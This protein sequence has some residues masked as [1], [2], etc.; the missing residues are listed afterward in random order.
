MGFLDDLKGLQRKIADSNQSELARD[1]DMKQQTINRLANVGLESVTARNLAKLADKL[2]YKLTE[3][4][5]GQRTEEE[6]VRDILQR[7]F[8]ACAESPIDDASRMRI[9]ASVTGK[10]I[11]GQS[12]QIQRAVGN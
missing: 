4:G 12:N 7:V 9:M 10:K 6:I 11:T 1:A 2:G 8:D 3:V 5:K